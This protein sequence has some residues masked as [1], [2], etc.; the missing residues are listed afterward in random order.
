MVAV[1]G[2]PAGALAATNLTRAGCKV[3]LFDEKPAWEKPCGGGLAHKGTGAHDLFLRGYA[4]MGQIFAG[5]QKLSSFAP[6]R[7]LRSA[8]FGYKPWLRA[9]AFLPLNPEQNLRRHIS[10]EE[11]EVRP[12]RCR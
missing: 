2:S 4:V 5:R 9:C 10:V 6:S 12:R 3:I 11:T 1:G 7:V 8:P